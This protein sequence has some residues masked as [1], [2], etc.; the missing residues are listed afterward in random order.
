MVSRIALP[1]PAVSPAAPITSGNAGPRVERLQRG[2]R[3]TL[4][5]HGFPWWAKAVTVDGKPGPLTFRMAAHAASMQGLSKAQVKRIGRGTITRHAELILTHEK[6]RSATMKRVERKRKPIFAKLRDEHLHP[7]DDPDNISTFEGV[8][9]AAWMVGKAPGPN[10]SHVNWLQKIRDAG[11]GGVI[12]SGART[13]Q[14]SEE[15]CLQMC[16]APTCPGR[17]AGRTS[18]HI[19]V[20]YPGGAVDVSEYTRFGELA[21]QVGAPLVNALG[22]ADPVHFSPSGH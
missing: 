21:R 11:W 15:L 1:S 16:G 13:A 10:G 17:C 8:P 20:I 18:N 7:P 6:E 2:I 12:T 14:H 4:D 9:V 3:Q 19:P 5:G 22:A